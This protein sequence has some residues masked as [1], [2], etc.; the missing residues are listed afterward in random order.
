MNH[1]EETS[2][3]NIYNVRSVGHYRNRRLTI[4]EALKILYAS[5][6]THGNHVLWIE[7][8]LVSNS[9]EQTRVDV[10]ENGSP[11]RTGSGVH[12]GDFQISDLAGE[13]GRLPPA[14]A[15]CG[16]ASAPGRLTARC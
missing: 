2:E 7:A 16:T 13:V 12:N 8:D 10:M 5:M 15:A 11:V 6:R 4:N 14:G 1:D 3:T 9:N